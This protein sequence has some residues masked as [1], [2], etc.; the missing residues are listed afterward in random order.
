[1]AEVFN[2]QVTKQSQYSGKL[3]S[4]ELDIT[5]EQLNK[6]YAGGICLQDAFPDLNVSQREFIKTGL[7]DAEWEE[8]FG[9]ES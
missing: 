6:Y 8:V 4:M 1:M 5:Q 9:P 3:R 7:T 2:M